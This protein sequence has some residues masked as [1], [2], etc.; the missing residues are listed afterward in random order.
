[1]GSRHHAGRAS[2]AGGGSIPDRG[3]HGWN[4]PKWGW[5]KLVAIEIVRVSSGLSYHRE[6]LYL[7][8]EEIFHFL[9]RFAYETE[10]KT[11]ISCRFYL[12]K[13]PGQLCGEAG[14]ERS[15]GEGTGST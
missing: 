11:E 13:A 9:G 3:K 15:F 1:M 6:L 10:I 14:H 4:G 5:G 12:E 8:P 2:R 7:S